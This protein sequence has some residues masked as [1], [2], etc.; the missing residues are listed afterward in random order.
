MEIQFN[1]DI[2]NPDNNPAD[3]ESYLKMIGADKICPKC[4]NDF[5]EHGI[6]ARIWVQ[7]NRVKM[8]QIMEDSKPWIDCIGCG[9]I[10]IES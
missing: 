5:I 1:I 4:G 3:F 10:S 2:D 9:K 8:I 7:G 6:E